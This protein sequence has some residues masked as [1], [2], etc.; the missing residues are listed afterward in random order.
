M[1]YAIAVFAAGSF[2]HLWSRGGQTGSANDW[3][4]IPPA[5][6]FL[7]FL[8]ILAF[9]IGVYL[10]FRVSIVAIFISLFFGTGAGY[11]LWSILG[12]FYK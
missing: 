12:R 7:R 8:S 5:H 10:A 4:K 1:I 6:G 2:F 11:V 3:T 9:I